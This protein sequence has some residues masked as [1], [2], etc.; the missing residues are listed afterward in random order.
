[1]EKFKFSAFSPKFVIVFL[2]FTLFCM[3]FA[4]AD[5]KYS[6][7]E[8]DTLV[9]NIA[10]YPDPL[11]VHVLAASTSREQIPEALSWAR[12]HAEM[13]GEALAS[14]L[15]KSGL[16]CDE[17][18]LALIPFP[19]VLS[20]MDKYDAWTS[21]LGNAVSTQESEV[22]EAVQRMRERAYSRG[23]LVSDDKIRVQIDDNIS[24]KPVRVDV[25]YV[26]VYN[27][28]V[29]YYVDAL[30]YSRISYGSGIWVGNWIDG[31]TWG[32][33][34]FDWGVQAMYVH[35]YRFRPHMHRPPSPRMGPRD[36]RFGPDPHR[37][38][39]SRME[40]RATPV[41]LQASG[42]ADEYREQSRGEGRASETLGGNSRTGTTHAGKA[43]SVST[44]GRTGSGNVNQDFHREGRADGGNGGFGRVMGRSR[45]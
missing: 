7:S 30:G 18:V 21:Q 12:G 44:S 38:G 16:S 2:I 13:K 20:M 4:N 40:P 34:W 42:K 45:R 3:G 29:V 5:E 41:P 23:H 39:Y 26:P 1:M 17:N 9:S 6:P 31:W 24:I 33:V 43:S 8:L 22:M 28:R 37:E 32:S 15:E 27:P 25:V 10:L 11:L 14:A 35:D 19:K 36:G